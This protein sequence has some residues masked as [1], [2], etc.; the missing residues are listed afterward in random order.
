MFLAVAC[1]PLRGESVGDKRVGDERVGDESV[2]AKPY[3]EKNS[4]EDLSG[5]APRDPV[6]TLVFSDPKPWESTLSYDTSYDDI[7]YP[8]KAWE[9]TSC[10]D[11]TNAT[12][13]L[14]MCTSIQESTTMRP[15][16]WGSVHLQISKPKLT[17]DIPYSP[18][19]FNVYLYASRAFNI[20]L[21][22]PSSCLRSPSC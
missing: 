17:F 21:K 9:P 22:Y 6:K 5:H 19:A 8:T 4:R 13:D 12:Q 1:P 10:C 14:G 16:T 18:R 2:G 20:Y 3:L 15:K 11:T 7:K